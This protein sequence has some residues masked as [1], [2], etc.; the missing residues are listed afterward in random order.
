MILGTNDA[1]EALNYSCER[2]TLDI[3][4]V[5]FQS[6][7]S[8]EEYMRVLKYEFMHYKA[9]NIVNILELLGCQDVATSYV[10]LYENDSMVFLYTSDEFQETDDAPCIICTDGDKLF[11]SDR[12]LRIAASCHLSG[13]LPVWLSENQTAM[14]GISAWLDSLKVVN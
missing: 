7:Y 1:L 5:I 8:M 13:K 9:G 11:D 3:A 6:E 12:I 10:V 2:G 4:A 14:D